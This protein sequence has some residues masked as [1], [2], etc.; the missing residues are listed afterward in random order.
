[1]GD[2]NNANVLGRMRNSALEF[3]EADTDGNGELGMGEFT[4]WVNTLVQ[5][6]TPEITI[7]DWFETIKNNTKSVT[8]S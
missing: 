3:F 8:V 1:M 4:N 2:R 5:K 7:K 6:P